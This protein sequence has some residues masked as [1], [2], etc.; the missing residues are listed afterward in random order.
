L[1]FD[2]VSPERIAKLIGDAAPGCD[3]VVVVCTNFRGA[4]LVEELESALNVPVIDSVVATTWKCLEL[5]RGARCIRGWG[6]LAGN[7]SFRVGLR[8]VLRELL[9][10]TGAG[11]ATVRLDMPDRRLH[12]DRVAA[13]LVTAGVGPI[14]NDATLDQWA[15]PTV[16]FI[17][18]EHQT[19]VQN[20]VRADGPPVSPALIELYGVAAQM[21]QP[22]LAEGRMYGWISVHEVGQPRRWRGADVAALERASVAVQNIIDEHA[23]E[24]EVNTVA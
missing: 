4:P 13:E 3:A 5:A 1:D 7:G 2:Q 20:D 8:A 19:L 18:R 10:A 9:A 6:D 21:L 24:M 17:A 14:G 22:L 16:Q 23:L 15:M 11:R 12:V